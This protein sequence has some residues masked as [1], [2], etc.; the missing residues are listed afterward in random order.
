LLNRTVAM[1]YEQG[2]ISKWIG[3]WTD[4]D[5]SKRLHEALRESEERLRLAVEAAHSGTY[6]VDIERDEIYCSRELRV[7]CGLSGSEAMHLDAAIQLI[8]P[9]DRTATVARIL[10]PLGGGNEAEYE[11][12]FRIIRAD[13]EVRWVTLHG[14]GYFSQ[15][16]ERRRAVRGLGTVTDITARKR[17]E[18]Q[19]RLQNDRLQLLAKAAEQLLVADDPSVMMREVFATVQHHLGLDGYVSYSIDESGNALVLEA[20]AG[21]PAELASAYERLS[22]GQ[23]LCGTVA[24]SRT[25]KLVERLQESVARQASGVSRLRLSPAARRGPAAGNPL[26]RQQASRF[27]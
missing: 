12:E 21:I 22:F 24:Q 23:A 20:S 2:R 26:V 15:N 16:G 27:V 7:I 19:L 11:A 5:S 14:R 13:G 4:I 18:E 17:A 10:E 9:D 1:K 3:T 8:H 6:D 25:P